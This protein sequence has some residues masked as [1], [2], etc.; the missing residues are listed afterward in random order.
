[1][2]LE[3]VMQNVLSERKKQILYINVYMLNLKK[4]D[5][6]DH[7]YKAEIDTDL[8]NKC[9]DTMQWRGGGMNWEFGIYIYITLYQIDN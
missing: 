2:D 8:E 1:M 7:I 3:I 5:I 9:M 4:I 6:E